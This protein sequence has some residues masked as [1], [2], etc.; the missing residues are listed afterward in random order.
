MTQ[1]VP[2]PAPDAA[3]PGRGP[4]DR[5]V[6]A[7]LTRA[8]QDLSLARSPEEIQRIVRTAA[9]RLTG[10]D[11]ATFVLRDEGR[12]YY[13]D[14]D[15]I[16]PLWKG[17][18][19]PLEACISGWAMLN[20]RHTVI[21]DIYADPRI[22]H[23]AYRPTFVKSLVMMPIRT[24][25]PIGAIGLYWADRHLATEQEIALARALADST[26]VALES[27]QRADRLDRAHR[28]AETDA[29][30]GIANRRA[31]ESAL[32]DALGRGA[33]AVHVLLLD[34][35]HF[36]RYN[37]A[38]GHPGGDAMLRACAEAWAHALRPTDELA[39]LGGEEF[40]AL[41]LGCDAGEAHAI[42]DR[43]RAAVP[44]RQTVSIGLAT[45][46]GAETAE[47]LVA[48]ADRALY[49]AKAAGRDRVVRAPHQA[50]TA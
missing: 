32:V 41:V 11:G 43:L 34:L 48:R 7:T 50:A 38:H 31:W 46:G 2:T 28:L 44:D 39:R 1:A 16:E 19:F 47:A 36:K 17:Q 13:V 5:D 14:E 26:A 29:L 33:R 6:V 45:W 27:V 18:R 8:I 20:R 42:A 49:A 21:E 30:T 12:C 22:P 37:D 9:R 35:D 24:I 25:D 3:A 4:S 15:A 23:E 40:G 10:A